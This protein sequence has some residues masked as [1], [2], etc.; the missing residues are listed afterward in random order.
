MKNMLE[1][2]LSKGQTTPHQ[3]ID[4]Q[5]VD[6]SD[7]V[8]LNSFGSKQFSSNQVKKTLGKRSQIAKTPNGSN[9]ELKLKRSQ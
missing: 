8:S 6:N 9:L 7:R 1:E 3:C 4:T 2:T 5:S